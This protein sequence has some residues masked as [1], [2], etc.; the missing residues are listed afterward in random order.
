[1]LTT[2]TTQLRTYL[3]ELEQT[4]FSAG[5]HVLGEA[6]SEDNLRAYL[7]AYF[8]VCFVICVFFL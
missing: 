2:Y 3:A 8:Q 4:L 5:L 1:M 6:P 7:E